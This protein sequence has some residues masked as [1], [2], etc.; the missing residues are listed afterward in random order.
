MLPLEF[1]V[2]LLPSPDTVSWRGEVLSDVDLLAGYPAAV[3]VA[4]RH[5]DSVLGYADAAA[6]I[7]ADRRALPYL[8]QLC[9]REPFHEHAHARLML[10]LAATGQQAAALR[11]FAELRQRLDADLGI[12]PS[13]VLAR[14]QAQVL[15]QEFSGPAVMPS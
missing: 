7:G 10:A 5:T 4:R 11:V 9:A 12:A 2:R 1:C 15:R 13:H 14:A 6:S 3:E 8:R